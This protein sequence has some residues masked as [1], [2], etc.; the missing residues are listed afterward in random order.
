MV[1]ILDVGE[2]LKFFAKVG[3][4]RAPTDNGAYICQVRTYIETSTGVILRRSVLESNV[5][6][7]DGYVH[8]SP[9]EN[10]LWDRCSEI[11]M[12][13]VNLY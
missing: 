2:C 1:D 5:F 11:S 8:L 6:V 3:K 4:L 13:I 12:R 10:D 9:E 7:L